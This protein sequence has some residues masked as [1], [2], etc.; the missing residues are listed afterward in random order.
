MTIYLTAQFIELAAILG[1]L[2]LSALIFRK[3]I[4]VGWLLAS[5]GA[6][7]LGMFALT[8]GYRLIPIPDF[9]DQFRF[10]WWGFFLLGAVSL[11][12]VAAMPNGWQR[13]GL[14][15]AQRGPGVRAALIVS[16]A[17]CALITWIGTQDIFGAPSFDWE[18]IAFNAL[19]VGPFEELFFRGVI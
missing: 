7:V 2:L 16:L 17:V 1:A 14:T 11:A 10:Y 18:A 8:S 3:H 19:A 9:F 4:K 13:S 6:I 12:I 15:L 5:V